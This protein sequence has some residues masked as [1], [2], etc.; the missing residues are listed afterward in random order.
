[1]DKNKVVS[2]IMQPGN[3]WT[4]MP[5]AIWKADIKASVRLVWLH[6]LAQAQHYDPGTRQIASECGLSRQSV[7]DALK[8]LASRG[9]IEVRSRAGAGGRDV[10]VMIPPSQWGLSKEVR[11]NASHRQK[12]E[13]RRGPK[14]GRVR[15]EADPAV[16]RIS[17]HRRPSFVPQQEEDHQE[18]TRLQNEAVASC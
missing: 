2:E 14:L 6:L 17:S 13:P 8:E 4:P 7:A 15:L 3:G 5:N 1:M 12:S 18:Q 9:M 11:L 10:Y 16:A